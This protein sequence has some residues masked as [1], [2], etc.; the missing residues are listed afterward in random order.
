MLK[1]KNLTKRYYGSN[2]DAVKNVSLELHKGEIF[3]Y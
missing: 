1:I 2:V 3:D